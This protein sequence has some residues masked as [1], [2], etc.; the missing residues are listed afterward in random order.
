MSCKHSLFNGVKILNISKINFNVLEL[1][2][3]CTLI[4]SDFSKSYNMVW[5][6]ENYPSYSAGLPGS[7]FPIKVNY[8]IFTN[9]QEND[10][11]LNS[12]SGVFIFKQNSGTFPNNS[13]LGIPYGIYESCGSYNKYN[14]KQKITF[15]L[16]YNM[17]QIL[18]F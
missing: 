4:S 3:T 18:L 6:I 14:K 8:T 7:P 12:I 9:I 17:L 10:K 5:N 1:N 15:N 13:E 16:N 2:G 11:A